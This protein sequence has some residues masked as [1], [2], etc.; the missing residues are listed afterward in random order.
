MDVIKASLKKTGNYSVDTD[1]KQIQGESKIE[2][3]DL[4]EVQLK[5]KLQQEELLIKSKEK[6][7]DM[8][9]KMLEKKKKE[10]KEYE[11]QH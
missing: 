2:A 11:R 9:H 7:A 8:V 5:Q 4:P 6:T 1:K 3:T 10:K